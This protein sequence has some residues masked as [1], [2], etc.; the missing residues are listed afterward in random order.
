[1]AFNHTVGRSGTGPLGTIISNTY[2][3]SVDDE[4][5]G[6]FT[7]NA[8]VSS[9][10]F[11]WGVI[12]SSNV[13]D[14]IFLAPTQNLTIAFNNSTSASKALASGV[15]WQ[16][17]VSCGYANPLPANVSSI[18]VSNAATVTCLLSVG[19]GINI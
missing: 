17:D 5:N 15:P 7:V 2:T 11:A 9:Q 10:S 8:T 4:N 1:M 14:F 3:L 18:F 6:S 19:C 16:W 13:Q 12:A